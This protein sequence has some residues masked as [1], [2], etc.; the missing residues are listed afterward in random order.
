M[1]VDSCIT[2]IPDQVTKEIYDRDPL[3][4][5][6]SQDGLKDTSHTVLPLLGPIWDTR[7]DNLSINEEFL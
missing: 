3:H 7:I 1:Y 5:A 4:K 2:S 6:R